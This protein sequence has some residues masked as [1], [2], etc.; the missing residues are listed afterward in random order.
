[1]VINSNEKS[2]IISYLLKVT[3]YP[4][5]Y[6]VS[7]NDDELF[8]LYKRIKDCMAR[9]PNDIIELQNRLATS[10]LSQV[11]TIEE[12]Q[13]FNYNKLQNIKKSLKDRLAPQQPRKSKK[14]AV[15]FEEEN[16]NGHEEEFLTPE[17]L[18]T[19]YGLELQELS[20]E[21][22][23]KAGYRIIEPEK[24]TFIQK[25]ENELQQQI[26]VLLS[27]LN[28][29][30]YS[31]A[32]LANLNVKELISLYQEECNRHANL[33]SYDDLELKLRFKNNNSKDES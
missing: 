33:P 5:K 9:Y 2:I 32:F 25:V 31:Q 7:K 21:E 1:M 28:P 12:L 18:Y 19:I 14:S 22:L 8:T 10:N 4:K 15:S 3:D 27:A 16:S 30:N 26:I 24:T 11:Y 29:Q 6:L 17:E 13:Q 20:S 23:Q